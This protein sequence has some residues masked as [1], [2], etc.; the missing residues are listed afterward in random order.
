M[1]YPWPGNVRELENACERIA[2]TC[3]CDTVRIGCLPVSVLFHRNAERRRAG[4]RDAT[5]TLPPCRSRSGFATSSRGSSPGRSRSRVE[6]SPRPPNC[7][8]SSAR[9]SG[10]A[11]ASS[12]FP[13]PRTTP[14]ALAPRSDVHPAACRVSVTLRHVDA[15]LLARIRPE[16]RG[17]TEVQ[18]GIA[19]APSPG[20]VGARCPGRAGR[21][22]RRFR[23]G[24]APFFTSPTVPS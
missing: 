22:D 18:A 12:A 14:R 8:R 9:R 7:C 20:N 17:C 19:I 4:R 5:R 15:Q 3:T 13:I 24:D 6:T 10:T 16:S 21:G 23:P 2:Q 11:F 1:R